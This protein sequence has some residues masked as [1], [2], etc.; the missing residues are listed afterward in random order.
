MSKKSIKELPDFAGKENL[1]EMFDDTNNLL[2][3]GCFNGEF[4]GIITLTRMLHIQQQEIEKLKKAVS[5]NSRRTQ[6]LVKIG[7]LQKPFDLES[8]Y[9]FR[10]GENKDE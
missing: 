7:D 10:Y 2:G 6:D 4:V 5:E 8:L 9:P 1:I 3:R